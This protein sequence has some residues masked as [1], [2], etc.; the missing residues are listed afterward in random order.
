MGGAVKSL[1]SLL[2]EFRCNLNSIE[3]DSL[4]LQFDKVVVE[5]LCPERE[6]ESLEPLILESE[7]LEEEVGPEAVIELL[8]D[9][10]NK[11]PLL[12]ERYVDALTATG[13]WQTV[14][15]V[16]SAVELTSL[17]RRELENGIFA[18]ATTGSI[19]RFNEMLGQHESSYEDNAATLFRNEVRRKFGL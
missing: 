3:G 16:V 4:L 14:I 17:S 12:R 11:K 13:D 5:I 10:P 9:V 8:R 1:L 2:E 18:C 15:D 7:R 6:D 19:D